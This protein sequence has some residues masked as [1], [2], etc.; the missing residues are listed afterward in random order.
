MSSLVNNFIWNGTHWT[1]MNGTQSGNLKVNVF[2]KYGN[3]ETIGA[4]NSTIFGEPFAIPLTPIIQLDGLYG[5]SSK[6]FETY[7]GDGILPGKTNGNATTN[8]NMME[9]TT[10]DGYGYG[11][12]RSKR[13]VRYRPGQGSLA[14]FTAKFTTTNGVGTLGYTQR[15]GFFSQEQALQIGFDTNG[16]FGILRQNGGKA[17]IE[18]L[19]ISGAPTFADNVTIELSGNNYIVPVTSSGDANITASE[20]GSWFITNAS[21]DWIVEWYENIVIFVSTSIGPKS[22]FSFNAGITGTTAT[23][24]TSQTGVVDTN[25]WIYQENFD[26]PLNGKGV[27][28]IV[29]DPSKLNIYQIDYRWLGIGIMRFALENPLNG[30]MYEFHRITFA[31]TQTSIHLDNPSMKIGYV[32]ARIDTSA[33]DPPF[34]DVKVCGGSMLGAIEGLIDIT[35]IPFSSSTLQSNTNLTANLLHHVLTLHNR[36]TFTNKI[37]LREL[38]LQELSVAIDT[39]TVGSPVEIMLFYEFPLSSLPQPLMFSQNGSDSFVLY[40]TQSG[41]I[42]QGTNIPI[43]SFFIT[44]RTSITI[45]LAKQRIII[46]PNAIVSAMVKSTDKITNVGLSLTYIED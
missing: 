41:Q 2:D 18:K 14:R 10:G 9:V 43:A 6:D 4:T 42:T 40:S 19:D 33:T 29:L 36:L 46:P 17:H 32:A 13:I 3:T 26:D 37:N 34:E 28:K 22:S 25:T 15:A 8:D 39:N 31:N 11:V 44:G 27:S 16:K 45:Y 21:S 7:I 23:I 24:S 35:N 12:I 5:L 30:D 20:I 38:I 1:R